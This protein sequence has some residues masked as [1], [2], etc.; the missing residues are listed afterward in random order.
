MR[1]KIATLTLAL[2]I[3]P[4]LSQEE[5]SF[6]LPYTMGK[7]GVVDV[8]ESTD[9]QIEDYYGRS[10]Y[11]IPSDIGI[12]LIPGNLCSAYAIAGWEET[13]QL[14]LGEGAD[15][16][17]DLIDRAVEVW[18]EAVTPRSGEP[19]I[20]I[21]EYQPENYLLSE[22][23]WADTDTEGRDNLFD[24]E[25]VIYFKPDTEDESGLWGLAWYGSRYSWSSGS[26]KMA[27]ADIYINTADEEEFAP[28]TPTLT[29][30]LVN[31][32]DSYGAYALYNKTYSVILHEIGHAVGLSHIPVSGNVMSKDF[33]AGGLDQWSAPIA[34]ELFRASDPKQDN[35]FVD[36]H[37][38]I[39]PYMRVGEENLDM[40]DR[41]DFF[42][43]SAKLG[44][45]EKM[46][47]TCIYEY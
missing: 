15:E 46:V 43:R 12:T 21:V 1:R 27:A 24:G 47:L 42:T 32:D 25:N 26:S 28:D 14:H 40:L 7:C 34:L 41:M 29:K 45:Q 19:L 30:L 5:S 11:V 35:K 23:F 44:E 2:W 10:G 6:P 16:Y 20:E 22:S 3:T 4:V 9:G 33:G 31:V 38:L 17:R 18:N 39:F 8:T 37:D 36:S 13:M